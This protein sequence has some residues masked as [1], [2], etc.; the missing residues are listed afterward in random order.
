MS[1]YSLQ[2]KHLTNLGQYRAVDIFRKLLWSESN[3]V[4]IGRN[5]I[6]VPD[7]INVGDGGL[8][9]IIQSASPLC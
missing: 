1:V 2:S 5:L 3:R 4:G 7:C 8:D 9:A 6:S